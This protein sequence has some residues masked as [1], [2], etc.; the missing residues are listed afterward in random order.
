MSGSE[1]KSWLID[2]MFCPNNN[3]KEAGAWL[4]LR[5]WESNWIK[6]ETWITHTELRAASLKKTDY[7]LGSLLPSSA[8]D[9]ILSKQL[10]S[11]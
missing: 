5:W 4:A 1:M 8:Q 3:E 11:K 6:N 10:Q 9:L 2:S 7:N